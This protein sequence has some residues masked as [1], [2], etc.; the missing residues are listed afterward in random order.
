MRR[1][2]AARRKCVANTKRHLEGLTGGVGFTFLLEGGTG[3]PATLTVPAAA[4]EEE[5]EEEED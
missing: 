5:A 2:D 4:A 1:G 3:M